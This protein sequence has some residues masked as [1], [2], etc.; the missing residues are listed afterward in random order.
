MFNF[1]TFIS[2]FVAILAIY[3]PLYFTFKKELEDLKTNLQANNLKIQ[4]REKK[5]ETL[6]AICI[7]FI[8]ILIVLYKFPEIVSIF[9]NIKL[10]KISNIGKFFCKLVPFKKDF[11]KD[12]NFKF[13]FITGIILSI[14]L[15][16]IWYYFLDETIIPCDINE[17]VLIITI[18]IVL[19]WGLLWANNFISLF[20]TYCIIHYVNLLTIILNILIYSIICGLILLI[21]YLYGEYF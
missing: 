21:I 10:L 1:S 18:L 14:I 2:L 16:I 5:I 15:E 3:I 20:L 4:N 8:I 19:G 17:Y 6:T 13:S 11:F 9:K 7:F 12:S